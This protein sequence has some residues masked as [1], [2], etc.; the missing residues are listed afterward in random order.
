MSTEIKYGRFPL[1][2]QRVSHLKPHPKIWQPVLNKGKEQWRQVNDHSRCHALFTKRVENALRLLNINYSLLTDSQDNLDPQ[3]LGWVLAHAGSLSDQ[4]NFFVRPA[5]ERGLIAKEQEYEIYK[6]VAAWR[7][8]ETEGD[9][10]QDRA[11]EK[12]TALDWPRFVVKNVPSS[13]RNG[14]VP[15]DV[16]ERPEFFKKRPINN[17]SYF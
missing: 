13:R 1:N 4:P 6:A 11:E 15:F 16:F 5:V 3:S 12:A 10:F 8:R 17:Q 14:H 2:F 9:T 7:E